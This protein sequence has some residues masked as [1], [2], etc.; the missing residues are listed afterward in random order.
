MRGIY[1]FKALRP[2]LLVTLTTGVYSVKLGEA[3]LEGGGTP[4]NFNEPAKLINCCN[5]GAPLFVEDRKC[6]YCLSEVR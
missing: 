2:E 3:A 4:V 5:C 6:S 1:G